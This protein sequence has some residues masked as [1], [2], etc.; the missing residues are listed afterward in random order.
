[1]IISRGCRAAGIAFALWIGFTG[2]AHCQTD[3]ANNPQDGNDPALT[4]H[5]NYLVKCLDHKN[6]IIRRSAI[7]A[8]VAVG[9]PAVPM[10]EH[11]V[12]VGPDGK[13]LKNDPA[14]RILKSIQKKLE[15]Q[16]ARAAGGSIGAISKK[17]RRRKGGVSEAVLSKVF[18]EIG[19]DTSL[20]AKVKAVMDENRKRMQELRKNRASG[21]RATNKERRRS[22]NKAYRE[23][24]QDLLGPEQAVAFMKAMAKKRRDAQSRKAGEVKNRPNRS[25]G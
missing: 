17:P 18:E 14:T 7:Q 16:A 8:L 2:F 10:V 21:D 25:D 13:V 12:K 3:R 9:K 22:L 6:R 5:V 4:T 23:K 11:A 15:M 19:I 1:M 20:V 24:L